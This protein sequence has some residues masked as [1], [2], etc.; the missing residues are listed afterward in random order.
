MEQSKIEVTG[1]P[2]QEESQQQENDIRALKDLEM[3]LV[4]GGSDG[5][6]TW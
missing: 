3:V 2:A 4:G 6:V 1:Q 5:I